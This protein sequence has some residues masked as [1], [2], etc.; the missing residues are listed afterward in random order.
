MAG[1]GFEL[2]RAIHET[3]YVGTIRGYLFAAVIS[4]G[5]WLLSILTMAL[6]GVISIGFLPFQDRD[7]IAGTATHSFALS[8][9]TTGVI[10]MFVTR[11]LADKLY[12][13]QTEAIAPAYVS[14]LVVSCLGQFLFIML[15]LS[16]TSLP[17]SYQLPAAAFYVAI[18]GI[19][20]S[21]VFLS[22][23]RDYVTIVG[24]FALGYGISFAG[25][26]ALGS[27]FGASGYMLGFAGGQVTLLALLLARVLAEF[28]SRESFTFAVFS[29]VKRYPALVGI[30]LIYN[31][32]FWIDKVVF[33]FSSEGISVNSFLN[34]FPAYDSSFF[35]ASLTIVPALAI[36]IVNIETD[37]Y[38][39]YKSFYARII[40]KHDWD[41]IRLAK[42]GMMRSVRSSYITLFKLQTG[43]MLLG[44]ALGP[45]VLTALGTPQS[46]WYI[47]RIAILA[48]G[49]QV[50]LL[51]AVMILLYLDLRGSVLIIS[52]L[53]LVLNFS[54]TMVTVQLGYAYY[55]YGF[56]YASVICLIVAMLLMRNRFE[57]LEYLTFTRQP[58]DP[59]K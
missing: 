28:D 53:F 47:F 12:M 18:C 42:Q 16:R 14:V 15:L 59:E 9:V 2:K 38:N 36:F 54:F 25:A 27:R 13:E 26:F 32:A 41:D 7:L 48:I 10:Q 40:N 4:S 22:A 37:F 1:I 11:Y 8:L 34:V 50:F 23:A 31:L 58:L 44:I 39:H 30:G 45:A 3:S 51:N 19:W 5:P 29:Y 21:M 24:C 43:I 20:L 33:W 6:L 46:H 57:H 17:L 55:G 35:L 56:L 52:L 49:V